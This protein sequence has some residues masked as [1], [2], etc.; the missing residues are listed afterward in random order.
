MLKIIPRIFEV[1]RGKM[2]ISTEEDIS[3]VADASLYGMIVPDP[4]DVP[5]SDKNVSGKLFYPLIEKS[6]LNVKWSLFVVDS[7]WQ[8]DNQRMRHLGLRPLLGAIAKSGGQISAVKILSSEESKIR[9]AGLFHF[10]R[11][12]IHE[13]VEFVARNPRSAFLVANLTLNQA[14]SELLDMICKTAIHDVLHSR[15]QPFFRWKELVSTS[16]NYGVVFGTVLGWA[17]EHCDMR[18]ILMGAEKDLHVLRGEN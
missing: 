8:T 4:E 7:A 10:S 2:D 3:N 15:R 14:P 17:E 5:F 16:H 12:Q 18:Y 1:V 6:S 11:N 9:H 13:V